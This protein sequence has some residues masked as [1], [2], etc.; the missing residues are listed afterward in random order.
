[1]MPPW[2]KPKL[3]PSWTKP[4]SG[5]NLP[6]TLHPF[7]GP[8]DPKNPA[9]VM[10]LEAFLPKLI[11][12]SRL[13]RLAALAKPKNYTD[14]LSN[15]PSNIFYNKNCPPFKP[16]TFKLLKKTSSLTSI[17]L[18]KSISNLD[19]PGNNSSSSF[20]YPTHDSICNNNKRLLLS[21]LPSNQVSPPSPTLSDPNPHNP[22]DS[23][24]SVFSEAIHT[25]EVGVSLGLAKDSH[26]DKAIRLFSELINNERDS[27][28]APASSQ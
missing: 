12:N 20:F 14:P 21:D 15:F 9:D 3:T 17:S 11:H 22:P 24:T 26:K 25:W 18:P 5:T 6:R 4:I 10:Q 27:R 7:F 23:P 8:L 28:S 2:T 13:R 19:S 1:M 16:R